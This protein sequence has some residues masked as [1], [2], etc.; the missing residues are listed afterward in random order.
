VEKQGLVRFRKRYEGLMATD[1]VNLVTQPRFFAVL[2]YFQR[3]DF[4]TFCKAVDLVFGR[5]AVDEQYFCPSLLFAVQ[6]CGLCEVST[7]SGATQW[8]VAHCGDVRTQSRAPKEIGTSSEWFSAHAGNVIPL[9]T[10]SSTSPLVLGSREPD[11]VIGGVS[12]V[13][14]QAFAD[15]VPPFKEVEDQLCSEVPFS[16]DVAGHAEVFSLSSSRWDPTTLDALTGPQL[17]RV[18]KEYSGLMYYVQHSSAR[19]RF[20]ILQPEWAFV[21]AYCLL[22][23]RLAD[24]LTIDGSTVRACRAVRLPILMYRT[25]FAAAD[26]VRVGPVVTFEN[27]RA[28]CIAGVKGYFEA[29]GGRE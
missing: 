3:G 25:L 12:G 29:S 11:G 10:D 24:I 28:T 13:F 9:I 18:R 4:A 26:A 1:R 21:A 19:V 6:V 16:D 14:D 2:R 7:V 17:F 27:V 5:E 8:W 20:K 15:L 22:P 23:W